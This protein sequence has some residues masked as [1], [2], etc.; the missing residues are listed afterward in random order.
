MGDAL[1]AI[2]TD[3]RDGILWIRCSG[4]LDLS[5]CGMLRDAI[6]AAVEKRPGKLMLDLRNLPFI[7]SS[8][9]RCILEGRQI[10]ENAGGSLGVVVAEDS[11]ARQ[12]FRLTG[13]SAVLDVAIYDSTHDPA[14]EVAAAHESG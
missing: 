14:A 10:A 7:D 13:T 8:G 4:E 11:P 12:L 1:L 5:S 2:T 9:L 6:G 3:Q